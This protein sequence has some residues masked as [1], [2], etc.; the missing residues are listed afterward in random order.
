MKTCSHCFRRLPENVFRSKAVTRTKAEGD[1]D[2]VTEHYN[3]S[4]G[5]IC[6][7]CEA[8]RQRFRRGTQ[9]VHDVAMD[10]L[11]LI[12]TVDAKERKE[13][14]KEYRARLKSRA[15]LDR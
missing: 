11:T 7:D 6:P 9:T 3:I 1:S 2:Y 8:R 10:T 14:L 12:G 15:R 5:S 13:R 4:I